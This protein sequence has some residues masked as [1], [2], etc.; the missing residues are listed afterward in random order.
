MDFR[1]QLT[2][3]LA[4]GLSAEAAAL[5]ASGAVEGGLDDARRRRELLV[6]LEARGMLRRGAAV[7][8]PDEHCVAQ[9]ETRLRHDEAR[10]AWRGSVDYPARLAE[11]LG[12]EAP[13]WV[14]I[15]GAGERL[16]GPAWAFVGSRQ[17]EP[18]LLDAARRLARAVADAGIAVASGMAA[19]ADAA[20]HDG[21]RL[22][23][24]GTIAIP[25]R[26]ILEAGLSRRICRSLN[27]TALALGRPEEPFS[28]G[29]AIRR[30]AAIA[31]MGD[32]LL[33]VAGGLRG[34]SSHA[35]RW[36]IA[37]GRPLWCFDAGP[38]KTPAANRHLL[39]EGLAEPLPLG[40]KPEQWLARMQESLARRPARGKKSAGKQL[41]LLE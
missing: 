3:I 25:A 21:A 36:A 37:W 26:G 16:S 17:T 31:A 19:G 29:L 2:L 12:A 34:G 4:R 24:A 6:G 30:N 7:A 32:G 1:Q 41:D 8:W 11:S 27:M 9:L 23:R 13:A 20:A 5:A 28:A 15:A 10:L 33:L 38:G 40:E 14:W 18:P 39:R 22:G 35:V